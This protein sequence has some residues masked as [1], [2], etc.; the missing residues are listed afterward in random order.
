MNWFLNNLGMLLTVITA[1]TAI[2]SVGIAVCTIKQNAK[3]IEESTRPYVSVE[4]LHIGGSYYLSIKNYGQSSALLKSM[5]VSDNVKKMLFIS[6]DGIFVN[7]K[8]IH[9]PPNYAITTAVN[10]RELKPSDDSVMMFDIEYESSVGKKYYEHIKINLNMYR[11]VVESRRS[12]P[13]GKEM[14][15]AVKELQDIA[16]TIGRK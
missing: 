6:E 7:G 13:N 1:V 5:K 10:D 11:N 14:E 12:I 8:D 16:L 9:M 2:I 4:V 15:T 3:A